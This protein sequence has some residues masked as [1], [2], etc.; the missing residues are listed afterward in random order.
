MAFVN[1]V[2]LVPNISQ[3]S[4][5]SFT[6]TKPDYHEPVLGI[7]QVNTVTIH[8]VC[9]SNPS[10]RSEDVATVADTEELI[11]FDSRTKFMVCVYSGF[12]LLCL[13]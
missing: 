3:L 8:F 11:N 10:L 1:L 9:F 2:F 7:Q 12:P 4:E 13:G 5:G 6:L